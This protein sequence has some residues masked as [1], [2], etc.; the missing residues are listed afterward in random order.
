MFS[1]SAL[2]DFTQKRLNCLHE[3]QNCCTYW[4]VGCNAVYSGKWEEEIPTTVMSDV[5]PC[6]LA[7]INV[8]KKNTASIISVKVSHYSRF[9]V[10][11]TR[12]IFCDVK[13]C[14][15]VDADVSKT[16]YHYY[17]QVRVSSRES[18]R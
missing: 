7:D 1:E 3:I 10:L 14:K 4:L 5:K 15:L 2:R 8:S 17:L 11:A 9:E 6:S 13:P 18:S 16:T 12:T